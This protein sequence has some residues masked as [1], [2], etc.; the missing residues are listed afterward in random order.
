VAAAILS[1][2]DHNGKT[3][4][5]VGREALSAAEC[6]RHL[7]QVTGRT[8]TFHDETV[9]EAW[10]SRARY[11]AP[12]FEVEGW[13]TSYLAIASG[14]MGP[15]SDIVFQLTGHPAQTLLEFL[16]QHPESYQKLL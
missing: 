1:D 10:A 9:A 6:A 5:V 8:I 3:R 7:S 12:D 16:E 4:D 14:E 15:E 11:G 2:G 13:I